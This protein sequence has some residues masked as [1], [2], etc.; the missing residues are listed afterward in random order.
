MIVDD[1][2]VHSL[3]S[4]PL[5]SRYR[6]NPKLGGT[7]RYID[8]NGRIVKAKVVTGQLEKVIAGTQQEMLD[9]SQDLVEDKIGI[10]G[11]YD[12]MRR[13]MKLIHHAAASIAKGGWAQ[14]TKSDLG[15]L[16][17]VTKSEYKFLGN[18]A[19]Q[20]ISGKQPLNGRFFQRVK[21]YATAARSTNQE[22]TRREVK[23][24]GATHEQRV[25]G[26]ADHCTTDKNGLLG[27]V[28][29]A[30][31]D[32]QLIGTLPRI[33]G[34]PCRNNC[35]CHFIYGRLENGEVVELE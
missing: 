32:W 3:H 24:G 13:R 20:I 16:G 21:Q 30:D 8:R 11:W 22:V 14:M 10:Q 34:T 7:G 17:S 18:F 9:I 25:L 23:S 15:F 2:F 5:E 12:G 28:E 31:L 19:T 33:G 6:F 1:P 29:L 27:C 26:I 35:R 4:S